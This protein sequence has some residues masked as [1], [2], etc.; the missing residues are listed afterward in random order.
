MSEDSQKTELDAEALAQFSE[1]AQPRVRA[2]AKHLGCGLDNISEARYSENAFDAEGH[3][4]KVLTDEEADE[5]T[6]E[7]CKESAWAF[8]PDFIIE[9]S[10]LPYEA[11][12]MVEAFQ[13]KCERANE[14][15]LA[16]IE[17]LEEFASDAASADGRGHFLSSYDGEENEESIDGTMYFLYKN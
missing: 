2:L 9:H 16:L 15:I 7:Y 6:L 5:A 17:N 8:N 1:E 10:K 3:E 13:E 14:T 11:R 4:W 12:E